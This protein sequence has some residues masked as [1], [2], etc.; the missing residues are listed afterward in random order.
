MM[1]IVLAHEFLST[2]AVSQ[3]ASRPTGQPASRAACSTLSLFH[4]CR[5]TAWR[6]LFCLSAVVRYKREFRSASIFLVIVIDSA[7]IPWFDNPT[8]ISLSPP[9]PWRIFRPTEI[10]CSRNYRDVR[11]PWIIRIIHEEFFISFRADFVAIKL[12]IILWYLNFNCIKVFNY[13]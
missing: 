2:G 9:S 1:E 10:H 13:I 8:P 7:E 6:R 3:P 11:H 5:D 12:T 4:Y